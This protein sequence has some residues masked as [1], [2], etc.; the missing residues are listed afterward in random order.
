MNG[1][2]IPLVIDTGMFVM[3]L[4]VATA[5]YTNQKSMADDIKELEKSPVTEARVATI[6]N[7]VK[8]IKASID[9]LKQEQT[10]KL[11]KILEKL[12]ED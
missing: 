8:H 5:M 7:D 12:D 9:E 1:L 4:I 6:E 10:E 2:K 3:G 11:D